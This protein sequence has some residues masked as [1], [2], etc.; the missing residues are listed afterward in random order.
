[1]F[2][3]GYNEGSEATGCSADGNVIV[4]TIYDASFQRYAVKWVGGTRTALAYLPGGSD[5]IA[6]GCSADGSVIVGQAFNAAFTTQYAVR[7]TNGVIT[8]LGFMLGCEAAAQAAG[9]SA[10]GWFI[11]GGCTNA[12]REE[13]PCVWQNGAVTALPYLAI[14][15]ETYPPAAGIAVAV[16]TDGTT[17]VGSGLDLND[18]TVAL[19]WGAAAQSIDTFPPPPRTGPGLMLRWS[20]DGGATWSNPRIATAGMLG[21]STCRV[22]FNRLGAT[23]RFAGSDRI[24]E[25]SS[26]D[27]FQISIVGAEVDVS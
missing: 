3:G 17:I 5:A 6:N 13:F 23:R 15:G 25:L 1:V 21:Q 26:S 19:Q 9:C 7:W 24:F 27:P 16:S 8:T 18:F 11:V 20:D 12:N 22:K 10:D 4:G 2:S 14:S